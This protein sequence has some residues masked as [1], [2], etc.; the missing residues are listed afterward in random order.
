MKSIKQNKLFWSLMILANGGLLVYA[1]IAKSMLV[2]IISL[3]LLFIIKHFSYD[4]LFKD[5]DERWDRKSKEFKK[6]RR[7]TT[8]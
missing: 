3:C 1:F 8:K 4:L 6:R 2:S 5:F 7:A